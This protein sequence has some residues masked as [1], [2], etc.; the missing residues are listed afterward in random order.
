M[1]YQGIIFDFNGVLFFDAD[2][3]AQSWQGIATEL[4]GYEM[5]ADEL[6]T[7]MH[8]RPNSYVMS[9]LA[10][11]T[12]VGR[13]LADLIQAKES[14]YRGLCLENPDRFV[15]SP[16]ARDLLEAVTRDDI[17]RTIATSSE[18]TNLEFFIK[19]LGLERWFDVGQIVYDDGNRPGKPA[20]D[21]Y[22]A[23]ARNIGV[24]PGDCVVVEDAV[25]GLLAA[26]AAGIGYIIGL[27]PPA[28]H[29]RLR[30]CRGVTAVIE[31][32]GEFPLR[33]LLRAT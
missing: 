26:Y 33:K 3:Q 6:D 1:K 13:E 18:I 11:R 29:A 17:P 8:G 15:L 22:F 23:A 19:H 5:T 30:A 28:A 25:A 14:L 16:G 21:I 2:F 27:G 7:H 9:Y 31:T 24:A 12:I 20:P 10:G 4:R 32:L